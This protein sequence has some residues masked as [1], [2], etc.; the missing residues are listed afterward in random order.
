M[1]RK[2]QKSRKQ[3]RIQQADQQ[4]LKKLGRNLLYTDTFAISRSSIEYQILLQAGQNE[5][6]RYKRLLR[7]PIENRQQRDIT[8]NCHK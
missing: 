4:P 2:T 3:N 8:H 7:R 1:Q 5:I 6:S